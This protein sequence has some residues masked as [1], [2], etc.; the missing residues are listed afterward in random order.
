MKIARRT[1]LTMFF[2]AFF[3]NVGSAQDDLITIFNEFKEFD[4]LNNLNAFDF[5]PS[6]IQD[7]QHTLKLFQQRLAQIDVESMPVAGQIDYHLVRATMNGLDFQFRV[8]RPWARDPGFYDTKLYGSRLYRAKFPLTGDQV[9][10]LREKLHAIPEILRRAPEY[11]TEPVGEYAVLAI[12]WKNEEEIPVFKDLTARLADH[13]PDLLPEAEKALKAVIDYRDWLDESKDTM[14]GRIG[15]GKENY[16]WWL[17]NVRLLPYTWEECM[18]ITQREFDRSYTFLKLEEHRNRNLPE[19]T[20]VASEE[21]YHQKWNAGEQYLLDFLEREEILTVPENFV[22]VGRQAWSENFERQGSQPGFFPMCEDRDPFGQLCHE[23]TGHHYDGLRLEQ[24]KR[25]IRS[26][27]LNYRV[28][29]VRSEGFATW[30]EETLLNAGLYDSLPR[31]RG[32]E[33]TYIMANYRAVRAR[34]DLKLHG[35]EYS[36]LQTVEHDSEWS[37]YGWASKGDPLIW[38]H[39][40]Q[41][42]RFPGSDLSYIIGKV[43]IDKLLS[44]RAHQLGKDFNLHDFIDDFFDSG[45]IPIALIRWEMTGFD[46]EIIKLKQGDQQ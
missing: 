45:N 7:R 18:A 28:S 19:L 15:V 9:E 4:N 27:R 30:I 2:I 12:R 31:G 29:Q 35:N 16:T 34:G 11:L 25:P 26:S 43:Q 42:S 39:M 36:L 46:D 41:V 22:P 1:S 8:F 13:H 6:A 37:P 20:P 3:L 5:S 40:Q 10:E 44:D 24:D 17:K 33:I 32:K 21:E 14:G 38:D 23:F